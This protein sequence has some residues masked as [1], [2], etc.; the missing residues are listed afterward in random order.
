M[1]QYGLSPLWQIVVSSSR[2]TLSE[3]GWDHPS[4]LQNAVH[5]SDT[6]CREIPFSKL[7]EGSTP[8]SETESPTAQAQ[9]ENKRAEGKHLQWYWFGGCGG[10]LIVM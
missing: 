2:A 6:L 1:G 10:S 5:L 7:Q 9:I 8:W 3:E 4:L